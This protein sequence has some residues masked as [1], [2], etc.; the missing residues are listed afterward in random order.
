MIE[1]ARMKSFID[2]FRNELTE[3]HIALFKRY[4][5]SGLR[6]GESLFYENVGIRGR[7]LYKHYISTSAK[8]SY[9]LQKSLQ[10][11]LSEK[12]TT[13]RKLKI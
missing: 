10:T 11:T 13:T 1:Q 7:H 2:E 6:V 8:Q 4:K 3:I 9:D 5:K 12:P